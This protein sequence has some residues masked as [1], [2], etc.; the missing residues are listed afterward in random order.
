MS[1]NNCI[2]MKKEKIHFQE[3]NPAHVFSIGRS[4]NLLAA[5]SENQVQSYD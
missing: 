4:N 3:F 2:E 5:F 1:E